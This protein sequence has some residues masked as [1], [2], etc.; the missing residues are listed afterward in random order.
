MSEVFFKPQVTWEALGG[1]ASDE[2]LIDEAASAGAAT[3]VGD[4]VLIAYTNNTIPFSVPLYGEN[5][6]GQMFFT[7]SLAW[8]TVSGDELLIDEAASGGV[9][10]LTGDEVSI[11]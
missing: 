4:E 5:P 2:A 9:A 7:A 11:G 10:A 6:P 1:A 8:V 3:L